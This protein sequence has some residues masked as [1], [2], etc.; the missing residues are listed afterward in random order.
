MEERVK[1]LKMNGDIQKLTF[2]NGIQVGIMNLDIILG[3]VSSLEI[4]DPESIKAELLARLK[5]RNFVAPGMENDYASALLEEYR[6]KH[7]N[8]GQVK[9]KIQKKLHAG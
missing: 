1:K 4:I 9:Q 5:V 7:D 6:N 3:E 2:P 8:S